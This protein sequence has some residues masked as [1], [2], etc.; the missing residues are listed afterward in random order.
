[1]LPPVIDPASVKRAKAA[2]RKRAERAHKKAQEAMPPPQLY[3]R[4][5]ERG[6][7]EPEV[8]SDAGVC[9][10][11]LSFTM[12]LF[13]LFCVFLLSNADDSTVSSAAAA[14]ADMS[15]ASHATNSSVNTVAA[16][17]RGKPSMCVW[18]RP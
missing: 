16:E 7:G 9:Y 10:L 6:R 4:G 1:M 8:S 2:A 12:L 11:L 14:A 3:Q 5:R 18:D 17:P 15:D 13:E